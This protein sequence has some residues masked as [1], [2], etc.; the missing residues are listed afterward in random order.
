MAE[1]APGRR[2]WLKWAC[3]AIVTGIGGAVAVPLTRALVWPADGGRRI[4]TGAEDPI[5]V[6]NAADFSEIP[7]RVELVVDSARD[8]WARRPQQRLGSA[9]VLRAEGE[10]RA[11]T[12]A[13]PH[14]GCSLGYDASARLFRCPCHE[15]AFDGATGARRDGPAP[16]GMDPLPVIPD[17][18][19]VRIR[20]RRFRPDIAEREEV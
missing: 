10:V 7:R 13:C 5:A 18:D 11:F 3:G 14:L 16:R 19:L 8:A 1:H 4:V 9:W 17:G 6:G 15:S 12:T 2:T 20:F